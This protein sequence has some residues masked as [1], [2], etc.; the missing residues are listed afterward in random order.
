MF[1]YIAVKLVDGRVGAEDL[2]A[3]KAYREMLP[4]AYHVAKEVLAISAASGEWCRDVAN[5]IAD[6]MAWL[7][8]GAL[9]VEIRKTAADIAKSKGDDGAYMKEIAKAKYLI[10]G[11]D[12]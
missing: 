3:A 10:K 7:G 11:A 2:D 8:G 5:R 1:E 12:K 4:A 6:L 9:E